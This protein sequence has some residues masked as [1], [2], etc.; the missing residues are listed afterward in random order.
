MKVLKIMA[1]IDELDGKIKSV[2]EKKGFEQS[3]SGVLEVIGI[4]E[5][6]KQMQLEKLKTEFRK[7]Y[8]L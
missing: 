3:V 8:K 5:N 6:I 2:L 4:L 7:D 1:K